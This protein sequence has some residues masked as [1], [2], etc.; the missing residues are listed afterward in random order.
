MRTFRTRSSDATFDLNL[1]P[2][3]DIIVSIVP[4]LLLST[5]FVQIKMIE[6]PTPQVVAQEDLKNPPKPETSIAL[7]LSKNKV[8]TFEVTDPAGKVQKN[9]L[10]SKD[11]QL[12]L[13]SLQASAITLKLQHP[14]ITKLQ[15]LPDA[16]IAFDELVKVMD[17]VRT[18]PAPEVKASIDMP[19]PTNPA[20]RQL[21]PDI[22]FGNVGG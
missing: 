2:F 6:A 15:L 9:A 21:F 22:I 10:A 3:L 14:E 20:E 12:D 16:E 18:K 5:A 11:G 8:M 13:A 17:Q 4:M 7:R 1:A 19:K